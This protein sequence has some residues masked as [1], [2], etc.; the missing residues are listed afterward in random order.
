MAALD[1]RRSG[2]RNIVIVNI[3]REVIG[4]SV[5][6]AGG[7]SLHH[8]VVPGGHPHFGSCTPFAAT[9]G[10]WLYRGAGD[11]GERC[12]SA[13]VLVNQAP[14]TELAACRDWLAGR[15]DGWKARYR[16]PITL[17]SR[18]RTNWWGTRGGVRGAV[19]WRLPAYLL[20]WKIR[21]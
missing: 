6:E 1:V 7:A 17:L 4:A 21:V 13:G 20:K 5:K 19:C 18:S 8:R 16:P 3:G 10:P 2:R 14:W 9:D 15:M 12:W 11:G